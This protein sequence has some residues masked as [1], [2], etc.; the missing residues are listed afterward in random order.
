MP[1]LTNYQF[2]EIFNETNPAG[3]ALST[4]K[5]GLIEVKDTVPF[6][7][8]V[9]GLYCAELDVL[10][11]EYKL[12]NPDGMLADDIPE[13][14]VEVI[15]GISVTKA[16]REL[17]DRATNYH[18]ESIVFLQ[19]AFPAVNAKKDLSDLTHAIAAEARKAGM[20]IR[21]GK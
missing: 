20:D 16:V 12:H 8:T 2:T 3:N 19:H 7:S 18:Q 17:P 21:V 14:R 5:G 4:M 15:R 10:L 1:K 13:P 6:Y 9:S 11:I